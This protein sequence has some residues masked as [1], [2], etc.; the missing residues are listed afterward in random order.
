MAPNLS[1]FPFELQ[2]ALTYCFFIFL[3][4]FF[5]KK[6]K[7]LAFE[8]DD[9]LQWACMR[10]DYWACPPSCISEVAFRQSLSLMSVI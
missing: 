9:S 10:L 8:D 3:L 1:I 7:N 4:L 6:K 2:T 5:F